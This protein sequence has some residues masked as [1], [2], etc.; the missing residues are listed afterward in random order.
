MLE[1]F[2]LNKIFIIYFFS[3]YLI[4]SIPF[5]YIFYKYLKKK[6]I[7]SFGSGNIGATNVNRLLGKKIGAVTLLL[8]FNKVLIP[9]YLSH[10][11]LGTGYGA[12]CG[13]CSILGHIYPIWLKFKGGKGVAGF[14]GFLLITSWPLCFLFLLVWLLSVKVLKYS[15]LGAI[16]SILLNLVFFK[17]S[18]FLQ[19][20][21][22]LFYFIPGEPIELNLMTFISFII[23][24]RHKENIKKLI[25][26]KL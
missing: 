8:D 21:Y 9:T 18:L 15:A 14:I 16:I 7:R 4:G 11:Y 12:F 5:G 23:L 25:S 10:L 3:S 24:Y 2:T 20:N 1:A 13:I 17:A 19:F 26:K 6:D 22:N